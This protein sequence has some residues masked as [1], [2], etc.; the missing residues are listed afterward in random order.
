MSINKKIFWGNLSGWN[1]TTYETLKYAKII[2]EIHKTNLKNIL[3]FILKTYWEYI[4]IQILKYIY[5]KIKISILLMSK[6]TLIKSIQ[7]D[8]NNL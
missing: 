5:L 8:T 4:V 6:Y 3:S 1:S 2:N 7:M